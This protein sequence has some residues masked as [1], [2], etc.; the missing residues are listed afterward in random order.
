METLIE[1]A[2]L[3]THLMEAMRTLNAAEMSGDAERSN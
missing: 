3:K 1:R 2:I